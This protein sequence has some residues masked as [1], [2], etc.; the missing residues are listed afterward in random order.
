MI[1]EIASAVPGGAQ[2]AMVRLVEKDIRPCKACYRCLTGDCP[3]KDDFGTVLDAI[4]SADGVIVAA[5][6]YLHGTHSSIQRFVDRGLQFWKH[7]ERLAE[8]PAVAVATAGIENGE[9][10]ALLGVENL[11]RAMGMRLKGR[12]VVHAALPG[13]AFLSEKGPRIAGRLAGA[14]FAPE[15]EKPSGPGCA[16]CGGTYFEFRGANG[17]YCL[18]CGGLGTVSAA[19]DGVRVDVDPPAH[20]WMGSEARKAHG[21][22]LV[23]MKQKFLR[24]RDRLKAVGAR[25][26]GGEFL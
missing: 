3:L 12:A 25:Y 21:E 22:W 7:H 18:S 19:A 24:E 9:G 15:S 20:P 13:E 26:K 16:H 2:L 14:L 10:F 17:I 11:V 5:P 6:S 1:K 4:L 23:G 8:K